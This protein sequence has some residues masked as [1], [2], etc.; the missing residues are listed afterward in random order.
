MRYRCKTIGDIRF[1]HPALAPEGLIEHLQGIVDR[2]RPE[3]ETA[4]QN[5]ASK[6]G[7][8]TVFSGRHDAVTDGGYR[9]RALV[10]LAGLWYQ[11]PPGRERPI[12]LLL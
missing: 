5:S 12:S 2:L 1:Y 10:R 3:T 9:Q 6:T 4:G 8:I 11:H 7:S